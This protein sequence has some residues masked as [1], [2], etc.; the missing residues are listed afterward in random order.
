MGLIVEVYRAAGRVDCT[1][2][3]VS[4]RYDSLTLVNVSGPFEP[5]ANAPAAWIVPHRTMKGVVYIVCEDPATSGKWPMFGGN[6]AAT[7]DSRFSEAVRKMTGFE[8]FHG[9]LKIHDRYE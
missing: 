5:S 1:N 2:D 6:F 8:G 4:S 9:A 3:G 7:S